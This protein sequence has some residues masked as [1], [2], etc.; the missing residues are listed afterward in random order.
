MLRYKKPLVHKPPTLKREGGRGNLKA[1]MYS[2]F[3]ISSG[4]WEHI[5]PTNASEH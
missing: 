3:K 5:L 4:A 1:K 2:Q